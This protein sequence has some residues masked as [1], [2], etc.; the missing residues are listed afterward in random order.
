VDSQQM[1]RKNKIPCAL[2]ETS[3]VYMYVGRSS[4]V[5]TL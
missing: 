3:Q 1:A 5:G 4:Q 2:I